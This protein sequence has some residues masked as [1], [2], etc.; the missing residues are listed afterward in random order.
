MTPSC[1]LTADRI[2]LPV[3]QHNK[4]FRNVPIRL[5]ARY[6]LLKTKLSSWGP[7]KNVACTVGVEKGGKE[8]NYSGGGGR[9]FPSHLPTCHA[10]Y[11]NCNTPIRGGSGES[12]PSF[13]LSRFSLANTCPISLPFRRLPR[14]LC[15]NENKYSQKNPV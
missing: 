13:F 2:N 11:K 7:I 8:G 1:K 6:W 15:N 5:L 12:N 10:G 9:P 3:K 14:R 4:G